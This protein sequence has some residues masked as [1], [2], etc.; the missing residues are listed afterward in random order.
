[1]TRVFDVDCLPGVPGP[2]Q[3]ALLL[4][5][6]SDIDLATES[7][8]RAQIGRVAAPG[9]VD[10]VLLDLS[11]AFVGVAVLRCLRDVA[12]RVNGHRIPLAVIGAPPWLIDLTPQLALPP[13]PYL[14]TVDSAVAVL[15]GSRA[16]P[17]QSRDTHARLLTPADE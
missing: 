13:L 16:H 6:R 10:A 14:R 4:T 8:A 2:G 15:K 1:M 5:A 9:R 7:S 17:S 11:H 12:C 3:R